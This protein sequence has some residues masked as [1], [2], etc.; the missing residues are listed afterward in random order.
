[1]TTHRVQ[2]EETELRPAMVTEQKPSAAPLVQ[3]DEVT[4]Q[5]PMVTPVAHHAV[6]VQQKPSVA[7][8][9]TA[10]EDLLQKLN[11]KRRALAQEQ[12]AHGNASAE[13]AAR[14]GGRSGGCWCQRY[15]DHKA[16]W[17][18]ACE[19]LKARGEG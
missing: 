13:V 7:T 6:V 9:K 11:D 5:K 1:M 14:S 3:Q 17:R 4:E 18:G 12:A 8:F 10:F 19:I 16:C 15:A 2:A